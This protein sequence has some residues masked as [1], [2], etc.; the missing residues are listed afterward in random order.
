MRSDL[1]SGRNEDKSKMSLSNALAII[2]EKAK[3]AKTPDDKF[4]LMNQ[5]QEATGL[6]KEL[7]KSKEAYAIAKRDYEAIKDTTKWFSGEKKRAAL[8][9]YN[10]SKYDVDA[11]ESAIGDF[12]K[13]HKSVDAGT[14]NDAVYPDEASAR[15]A[16]RQNGDT[17]IMINPRTGKPG[18]AVL[19]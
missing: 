9:A 12:V 16:G 8:A 4:E 17:I 1:D 5:K 2:D 3:M 14:G 11:A 7:G 15:K 6:Y 13:K 19:Q 18:R 10:S